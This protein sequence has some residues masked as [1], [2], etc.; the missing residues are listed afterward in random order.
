MKWDLPQDCP[1]GQLQIRLLPRF[2]DARSVSARKMILRTGVAAMAEAFVPFEAET[3]SV[4]EVPEDVQLLRTRYP[5]RWYRNAGEKAFQLD[6]DL[7]LP[8]SAPQPDKLIY[9]NMNP[10]ITESKVMKDK[11]VFRGN[12]NL[13]IL[14]R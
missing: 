12:G 11:V 6:E 9:Y 14:Y 3:W 1:E 8:G 13:H 10:D 5:V 7:T 4:G 2:V